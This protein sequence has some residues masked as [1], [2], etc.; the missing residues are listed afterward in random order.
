MSFKKSNACKKEEKMRSLQKFVACWLLNFE[1]N[2]LR[3][4]CLVVPIIFVSFNHNINK[5][6][7]LFGNRGIH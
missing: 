5:F 3:I 7:L 2:Y 4:V 1:I 6:I